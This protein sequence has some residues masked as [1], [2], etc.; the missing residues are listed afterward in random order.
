MDELRDLIL[1]TLLPGEMALSDL[2]ETK[3]E[4][5][6]GI[7]G[8]VYVDLRAELAQR[9]IHQTVGGQDITAG[10]R[11]LWHD[12]SVTSEDVSL[13]RELGVRYATRCVCQHV[14]VYSDEEIETPI[15]LACCMNEGECPDCIAGPGQEHGME[16]H[17]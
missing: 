1:N 14:I 8:A 9:R 11:A 12:D 5:A 16:I 6:V 4:N 10:E 13:A 3:L 2:E 17:H 15:I 7:I